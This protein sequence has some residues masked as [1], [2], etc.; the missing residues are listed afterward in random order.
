MLGEWSGIIRSLDDRD[1]V[2]VVVLTGAGRAFT[3]GG[4]VGGFADVATMSP[5]EIKQ[6]VANMQ[7]LTSAI[8]ELSKPT[9]AAVNGVATGGGLDV[10]LACDMRFVA[11]DAKLAETYVRMGLVPGGGG[12]YL[13]PRIVGSAKALELLLSAEFITGAEA[14]EIGL[15]NRALPA[16]QLLDDTLAFA[17]KIADNAPISVQAIKRMVRLGENQD[18]RLGLELASSTLATVRKTEDHA[19]AVEAFKNKT[20][21][22]FVGR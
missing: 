3:T 15:A 16:E 12:A 10:A 11:S 13:L 14:A 9:I 1:D 17:R 21:P 6:E 2:R 5:H 7:A 19:T 8:F 22:R 20:T 18:L 4:D